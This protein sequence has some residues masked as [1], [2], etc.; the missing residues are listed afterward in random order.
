MP[1]KIFVIKYN[2]GPLIQ[3]ILLKNKEVE[4][5]SYNRPNLITNTTSIEIHTKKLDPKTVFEES[6]YEYMDT[7]KDLK[8]T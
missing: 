7:L 6:I 3:S 1:S 4:F 5:A 8:I 2:L